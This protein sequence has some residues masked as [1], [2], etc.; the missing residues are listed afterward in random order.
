MTDRKGRTIK[1]G[2]KL[3]ILMDDCAGY[4]CT[5]EKHIKDYYYKIFGTE[6]IAGITNRSPFN[7]QLFYSYV[8][9]REVEKLPKNFKQ[10]QA[11]L[12]LVQLEG[13]KILNA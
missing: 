2:D 11:K 1:R 9:R 3:L 4:I 5:Y 6:Y 13:I 12:L 8:L 10:Y 7:P